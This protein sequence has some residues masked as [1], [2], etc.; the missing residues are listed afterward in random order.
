MGLNGT[1]LA[2]SES[3]ER[4]AVVVERKDADKFISLANE[5]NL[6]ATKIADVTDDNRLKM[7]WRDNFIVDISR[8]FLNTNGVRREIDVTVECPDEEHS[9]FNKSIEI[10]DLNSKWIEHLG[11]LNLCS[12]K[13]LTEMFD[14]SIGGCSVMMPY[15]GKY[16]ELLQ[17]LWYQKFLYL[18]EKLLQEV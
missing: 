13:G 15:G 8:D 6:E 18:T 12:H 9:Y 7:L 17:K 10:D 16:Q 4:M 2:I 3:Q 1:E 5:E 11:N 14:S